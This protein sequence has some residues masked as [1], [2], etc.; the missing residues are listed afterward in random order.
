MAPKNCRF[1]VNL[2]L[3]VTNLDNKQIF[4]ILC[5]LLHRNFVPSKFTAT[6][7]F[8]EASVFSHKNGFLEILKD[9]FVSTFFATSQKWIFADFKRSVFKF[10]E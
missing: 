3:S 4:S 9:L 8:D 1:L 6:E 10:V 2:L 5:P 7:L